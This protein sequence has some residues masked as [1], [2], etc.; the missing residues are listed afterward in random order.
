M[1]TKHKGQGRLHIDKSS[2]RFAESKRR[3]N[4]G[5]YYGNYLGQHGSGILARP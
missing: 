2:I 4:S 3:G 5:M 1:V